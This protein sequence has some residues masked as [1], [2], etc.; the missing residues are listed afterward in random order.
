MGFLPV[1]N[2]KFDPFNSE[3]L[4]TCGYEHMAAW[5]IKG[6]HLSCTSFQKFTTTK[7]EKVRMK[8]K[9]DKKGHKG[10]A[11]DKGEEEERHPDEGEEE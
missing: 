10:A 5:R 9:E 4:I 7:A 2:V 3:K 1:F 6:T 11:G 8:A